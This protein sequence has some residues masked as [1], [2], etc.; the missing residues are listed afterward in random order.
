MMKILMVYESVEGHTRRVAERIKSVLDEAGN[1]VT[2]VSCKSASPDLLAESDAILLGGSIH[3]GRHNNK[4]VRFANDHRE[5][6]VAKPNAFFLVC[7]TAKSDA[8]EDQAEVANYLKDFEQRSGFSPNRS[9]AFAGALL[10]TQYNFLKRG[11]MKYI[12]KKQGGDTDTSR[13]FVYTDW[14]AVEAFGRAFL[15]GLS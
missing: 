7:L 11:L 15:E 12:T 8:P 9:Q 5:A 14:E 1:T 6:L 10:Y 4:V 13:D 2:L 3:A